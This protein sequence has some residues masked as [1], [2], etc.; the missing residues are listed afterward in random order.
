MRSIIICGDSP[1]RILTET[2]INTCSNYGG[3]QIIDDD[4]IYIKSKKPHF[5]I[6]VINKLKEL[7]LPESIVIF[8]NNFKKTKDSIPPDDSIC[9]TDTANHEALTFISGSRIVTIG[10]S[11]SEHDTLGISGYNDDENALVSLKRCIVTEKSII[12]PHDFTVHIKK[13]IPVYPILSASAVLLLSGIDTK[14]GYI[15][16]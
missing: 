15:I 8:G 2:V 6:I 13:D 3:A 11:M 12:E 9:I 10:C 16:G 4:K 5:M 14:N 7:F 1:D